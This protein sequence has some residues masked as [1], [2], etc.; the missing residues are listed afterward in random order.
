MNND[1]Y[2][3]SF[4]RICDLL[5]AQARSAEMW[6]KQYESHQDISGVRNA[7]FAIGK[8]AGHYN[9]LLSTGMEIPEDIIAI[10]TRMTNVWDNLVVKM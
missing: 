4:N 9:V 7:A 1:A 3:L 6:I 10:E 5:R 8:V 2:G